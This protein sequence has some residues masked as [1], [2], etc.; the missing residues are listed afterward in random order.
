MPWLEFKGRSDCRHGPRIPV[1]EK[2]MKKLRQASAVILRGTFLAGRSLWND[3]I[4]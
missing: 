3:L 1:I 2:L 4:Y